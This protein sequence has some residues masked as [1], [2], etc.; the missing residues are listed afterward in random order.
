VQLKRR[1][2]LIPNLVTTVTAYARH[3]ED[4]LKEVTEVRS[5]FTKKQNVKET[6]ELENGVSRSLKTLLALVEAYPDLKADKNFL[7]LQDELVEIEDHLQYARRY[8]NG[9]VRD[10]NNLVE[11]FPS[12]LVCGLLGGRS[13][14]YF[15]I[16]R[17]IE[18][19]V[20]SVSMTGRHN[21][22]EQ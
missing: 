15:E 16:D 19:Q 5:R 22:S 14:D 18:R 2:N 1:H 12:N 21:E 11:S 6:G 20:P 10:L 4:V 9:S 17:A 13:S 3:E 8:Y 7:E